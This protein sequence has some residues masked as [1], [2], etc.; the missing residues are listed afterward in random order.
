MPGR[1]LIADPNLDSCIRL[2]ETLQKQNYEVDKTND[3]SLVLTKVC[4]FQP[5]ILIL[6]V[7]MPGLNGY[8]ICSK[9]KK[10]SDLKDITIILTFS[11]N[12][13][14]DYQL[15]RNAGATRFLPKSIE[16]A[17]LTSLLGFISIDN[18]SIKYSKPLSDNYIAQ[19]IAN[20]ESESEPN[21][22]DKIEVES[23]EDLE[24]KE[25]TIEIEAFDDIEVY[26]ADEGDIETIEVD[27]SEEIIYQFDGEGTDGL[28][29]IQELELLEEIQ[30]FDKDERTEE[31]AEEVGALTSVSFRKENKEP[32]NKAVYN[33]R[34]VE[35][36]DIE[37][38]KETKKV[39]KSPQ[40]EIEISETILEEPQKEFV[41]NTPLKININSYDQEIELP[42]FE[43]PKSNTERLKSIINTGG[44]GQVFEPPIVGD[45]FEYTEDL[46]DPLQIKQEL[47]TISCRECGANV[48]M[49]DVFCVECGAAV[50]ESAVRVPTDFSCN[51]CGQI[52]DAGDV[53][54]LNCGTVQ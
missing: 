20:N 9:I 13:N 24:E 6:Y 3:G 10:H 43:S 18:T 46:E 2:E 12:D 36:N 53:F 50:D 35:T 29:E 44:L 16:P 45:H 32:E 19:S 21:T 33:L 15:A 40:L 34:P 7:R 49:E 41:E 4:E 47:N 30:E 5:H 28:E 27:V 25:P 39:K 23:M 14:F 42:G 26:D 17:L 11:E 54:C 38:D 1:V 31:Y 8:D 52:V 22:E 51:S 48:L 37:Q